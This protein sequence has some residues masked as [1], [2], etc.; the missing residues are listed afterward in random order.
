MALKQWL[1]TAAL[2][3]FYCYK[4][5]YEEVKAHLLLSVYVDV[6]IIL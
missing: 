4:Q 2:K 5:T 3:C 1:T 6:K